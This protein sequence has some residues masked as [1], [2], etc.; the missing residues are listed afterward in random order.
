MHTTALEQISLTCAWWETATA[1]ER[2]QIIHR[3]AG[4]HPQK[5]DPTGGVWVVWGEWG[6]MGERGGRVQAGGAACAQ[7]KSARKSGDR[8][9]SCCAGGCVPTRLVALP[10]APLRSDDNPKI[11]KLLP[12]TTNY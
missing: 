2:A 12:Y 6:A 5:P 4:C 11:E 8:Y 9:G 10:H 7:S 1:Q 3:I